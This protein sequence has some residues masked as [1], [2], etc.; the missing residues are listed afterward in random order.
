MRCIASVRNSRSAAET[1]GGGIPRNWFSA[2]TSRWWSDGRRGVSM[3]RFSKCCIMLLISLRC[4]SEMR[5][6]LGSIGSSLWGWGSTVKSWGGSSSSSSG[7]DKGRSGVARRARRT[8]G[9]SSG[10][11]G[12]RTRSGVMSL[13]SL[14]TLEWDLADSRASAAWSSVWSRKISVVGSL[15]RRLS[16]TAECSS[17]DMFPSWRRRCWRGDSLWRR[18]ILS[19][20]WSTYCWRS[21]GVLSMLLSLSSYEL[22]LSTLTLVIAASC[23]SMFEVS[24]VVRWG[25]M[26]ELSVLTKG[27]KSSDILDVGFEFPLS[28]DQSWKVEWSIVMR[29]RCR[30]NV[31]IQTKLFL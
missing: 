31:D 27:G 30:R 7:I 2:F 1:W 4:V 25:S 19:I 23:W 13:A 8:T 11:D 17:V 9:A 6:G 21:A 12:G 10:P 14:L 3:P 22:S 26:V 24:L 5:L 29:C 18:R 28:I 20:N 15:G 16:E